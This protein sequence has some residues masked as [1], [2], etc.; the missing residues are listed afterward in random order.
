MKRMTHSTRILAVLGVSLAAAGLLACTAKA[1]EAP[2]LQTLFDEGRT[3]FYDA[4]AADVA[5]HPDRGRLTE[6]ERAKIVDLKKV[7]PRL[8]GLMMN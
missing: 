7:Y 4:V 6:A 5:A 2:S 8:Y 1:P 3:M